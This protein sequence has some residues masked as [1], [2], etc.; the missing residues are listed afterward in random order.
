M[1]RLG[2]CE[3]TRDLV[4]VGDGEG[5]QV[6]EFP[7]Q[8][9]GGGDV[10]VGDAEVLAFPCG[11]NGG[12][13]IAGRARGVE[14]REESCEER[15]ADVEEESDDEGLALIGRVGEFGERGGEAG[16]EE[17]LAPD[18]S[19]EGICGAIQGGPGEVDS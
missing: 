9:E 19:R 16:A 14:A 7:H 1:D 10:G 8:G 5:E 18:L 11:A 17:R 12:G 15:D 4:V 2:A 13:E 6:G 3:I